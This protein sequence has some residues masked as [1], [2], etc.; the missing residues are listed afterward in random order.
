MLLGHSLGGILATEVALLPSYSTQNPNSRVHRILG[1]IAYDTPFLGLHPSVVSTGITSLFQSNANSPAKGQASEGGS[2]TAE[3]GPLLSR[4]TFSRVPNDPNYNPAFANDTHITQRKGFER[5][6][7]FVQKHSDDLARASTNY[8]TSYLEFGGCLADYPGLKRRYN[9]LRASEAANELNRPTDEH[10]RALH[11]IRFVNYYTASTGRLKPPNTPEAREM[12]SK[13]QHLDLSSQTNADELDKIDSAPPATPRF[14]LEEHRSDGTMTIHKPASVESSDVVDRGISSPSSSHRTSSEFARPA[15][16]ACTA[17]GKLSRLSPGLQSSSIE[18]ASD[19][20]PV[21]P[22]DDPPSSF[23]AAGYNDKTQLESARKEHAKLV[24]GYKQHKKDYEKQLRE[25]HKAVQKRQKA[26]DKVTRQA[27]KAADK[28]RSV[29]ESQ[30]L[31]RA[32]T[33]NPEVYDR[34]IAK[35]AE[36]REAGFRTEQQISQI[37]KQRD[38]KFCLLPSKDPQTC[39]RDRTW[40]RVYMHGVDEVTAHTSLFI[41]E[42]TTYE[43]LVGDTAQRI[44]TWVRDEQSLRVALES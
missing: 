28:A 2:N 35:D 12:E 25:R 11:R 9:A 44:E 34:Q 8:V 27:M 32:A 13:V 23:D 41:P 21:M 43:K 18:D 30:K 37:K 29:E 1:V 33:L 19:L 20:P 39:E 16:P 3:P 7:Y 24:K 42:G 22:L 6:I 40:I 17:E 10:G 26:A 4:N 36:E 15:E 14:S 38:R 31:K 5:L